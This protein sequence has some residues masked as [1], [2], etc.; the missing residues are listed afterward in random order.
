MHIPDWE[1]A[2]SELCRVLKPGG[3]M[4]I[5]EGNQAS[6]EARLA[7]A[8]RKVRP[9]RS[10]LRLAPG[11]M[12]FWSLIEGRPFL[13]RTANVPILCRRLRDYA[14]TPVAVIATEFWDIHRFPAGLVRRAALR[15][16]NWWLGHMRWWLSAG[17][18]IVATKALC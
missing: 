10:T 3:T 12:E 11:G 13:V 17:V 15:W 14:V 1:Q 8:V 18:G 2:L 6:V 16:N 9:S 5:C 4:I 7:R